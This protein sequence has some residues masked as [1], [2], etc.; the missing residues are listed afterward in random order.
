M[1][2]LAFLHVRDKIKMFF[3]IG[4]RSRNTDTTFRYEHFEKTM[5]FNET[6]TF[7]K[8]TLNRMTLSI[9]NLIATLSLNARQH[10]YG[11]G[12]HLV[13]LC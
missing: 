12:K 10:S 4:L 11:K 6:L 7:S 8:M 3:N 5:A 13:S 9:I 1:N 2:T